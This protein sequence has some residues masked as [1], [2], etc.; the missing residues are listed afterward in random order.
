MPKGSRRRCSKHYLKIKKTADPPPPMTSDAPHPQGGGQ[1]EP[2][3]CASGKIHAWIRSRYV[4]A[5]FFGE[6]DILEFQPCQATTAGLPCDVTYCIISSGN[7]QSHG[8][9][10]IT[11]ETAC[12]SAA[13]ALGING[14]NHGGGA[15]QVKY[16]GFWENYKYLHFNA[17]GTGKSDAVPDP[18]NGFGQFMLCKKVQAPTQS[19]TN[20]PTTQAPT[21]D[22]PITDVPTQ[23]STRIPVP[24]TTGSDTRTLTSIEKRVN[25]TLGRIE[26]KIDSIMNSQKV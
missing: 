12:T 21:S 17:A 5:K 16:C 7:C 13:S 4:C 20:A 15:N 11:T 22:T 18:G 26:F 23:S 24:P 9:A 3:G 10:F 2:S 1:R 19:P 25:A 6:N 14:H 8:Y